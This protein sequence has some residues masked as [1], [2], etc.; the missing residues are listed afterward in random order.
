MSSQLFRPLAALLLALG[1]L[2]AVGP[3]AATITS[4]LSVS[5][6][7]ATSVG[8]AS[9]S[10]RGSSRSLVGGERL[11]AAGEYRV[12]QVALLPAT[13]AGVE[14]V[15]VLLEPLQATAGAAPFTLELPAATLQRTP[16]VAGDVL[17]AS[18]RSF[19]VEFA[20]AP[21]PEPFFLVLHDDLFRE[22]VARPLGA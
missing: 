16:L 11:V 20:R 13:A 7:L 8:S 5:E 14:R 9:D 4:S 18:P 3:A 19:G 12:M 1:T 6:S 22:L 15:H 17:R 2:A 21:A 10:L